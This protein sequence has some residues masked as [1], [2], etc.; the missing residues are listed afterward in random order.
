MDM[1][2]L[3]CKVDHQISVLPAVPEAVR[4]CCFAMIRKSLIFFSLLLMALQAMS[5]VATQSQFKSLPLGSPMRSYV[6]GAAELSQDLSYQ[7]QLP[8]T[9]QPPYRAVVIAHGSGGVNSS[10]EPWKKFFLERGF[11]VAIPDSYGNRITGNVLENQGRLHAYLHIVD[12]VSLS[13]TLRRNTL[14]DPQKTVVIGF[15]R[16][17]T[18]ALYSAFSP[19]YRS[20]TGQSEPFAAHIAFYPACNYPYMT[21]S[22]SKAPVLV[23]LGA[24]DDY[25]PANFCVDALTQNK[26][27]GLNVRWEIR[28]EA[29]HGFDQN[30]AAAYIAQAEITARC[31]VRHELNLDSWEYRSIGDRSLL[32]FQEASARQRQCAG[33]YFGAWYGSTSGSVEWSFRKVD[34][35]LKAIGL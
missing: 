26:L 29:Y 24:K 32:T 4:N 28:E 23:L 7:L 1:T 17:G 6:Q 10:L 30:S 34:E 35:F 15:S 5:Q 9:G 31:P 11:A 27:A 22:F 19:F 21:E 8:T 14:I 25:T 12:V 3:P 13:A 16:G 2:V 20:I 18:A 33:K